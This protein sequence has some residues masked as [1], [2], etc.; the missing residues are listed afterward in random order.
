M[1]D[2]APVRNFFNSI[3]DPAHI[4]GNSTEELKLAVDYRYIRYFIVNPA[5]DTIVFYGDYTLHGVATVGELAAQVVAIFTKDTFLNKPY[6]NV[7]VC[8]HTDFELIPNLYL[9]DKEDGINTDTGQNPILAGE[10]QF[11]FEKPNEIS[12]L[13]EQKYSEVVHYH[14]GATMI[15]LFDSPTE[16][17]TPPLYVNIAAES[18]EVLYFDNNSALRLFNRYPYRAFQDYIYYL[19]LAAEECTIDPTNARV[20]LMG[21]VSQDSKLYEM[22]YRYFSS[23]SFATAPATTRFSAAFDLYPKHLNYLLYNL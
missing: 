7:K 23:V 18:I 13:I 9:D 12:L 11:V 5:T 16:S 8:W 21:E 15:N 3:G 20:V 22:T 6:R 1:V 4:V 17:I 2:T 14:A 19:L 10:A